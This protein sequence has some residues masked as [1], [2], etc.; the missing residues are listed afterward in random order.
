MKTGDASPVF[1]LE[2]RMLVHWAFLRGMM[3]HQIK[4]V[5]VD[6]ETISIDGRTLVEQGALVDALTSAMQ[7]NPDVV[8]VI[9]AVKHDDYRGIGKV[10]YAS[11]HAGLPVANLRYTTEDGEVVTF[12]ELQ[13]RHPAAS[14]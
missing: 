9:E 1:L 3:D 5:I 13:K 10:I 4:A 11:Q 8:L 14:E 12:G 2:T 7:H 6:D